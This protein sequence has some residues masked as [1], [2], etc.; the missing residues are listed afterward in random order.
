M[1]NN[2]TATSPDKKIEVSNLDPSDIPRYD[3]PEDKGGVAFYLM[4]LFGIGA[5]L[6][7]NAVLTALDFFIEHV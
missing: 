7:W 3:E 6:P 5:L 1:D 2:T 4:L